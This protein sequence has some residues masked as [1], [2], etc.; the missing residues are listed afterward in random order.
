MLDVLGNLRIELTID[1]IANNVNG[2]NFEA[3][4]GKHGGEE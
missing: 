3:E 2:K 4:I 1:D